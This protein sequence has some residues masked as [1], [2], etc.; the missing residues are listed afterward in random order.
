MPQVALPP[1]QRPRWRGRAALPRA[2]GAAAGGGRRRAAAAAVGH[3]AR[4]PCLCSCGGSGSLG[5]QGG[6]DSFIEGALIEGA[7][8]VAAGPPLQRLVKV[9]AV[10]DQRPRLAICAREGSLQRWGDR[11]SVAVGSNPAGG[12]GKAA[13]RLGVVAAGAA[14]TSGTARS[15][16]SCSPS[17]RCPATCRTGG[18]QG[19]G[20]RVRRHEEEWQLRRLASMLVATQNST[21]LVLA[22]A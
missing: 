15:G 5:A 22:G 12:A 21:H 9:A 18:S 13:Q 16:R 11:G 14:G 7:L 20:A 10:V 1:G 3:V 19:H 6:V 8:P 2:A 17:N 4:L